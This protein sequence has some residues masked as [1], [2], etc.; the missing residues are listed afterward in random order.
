V[1]LIIRDNDSVGHERSVS[2][3]SYFHV[4]ICNILIIYVLSLVTPYL[5]HYFLWESNYGVQRGLF[6]ELTWQTVKVNVM[7]AAKFACYF[8]GMPEK[9]EVFTR[10]AVPILEIRDS[11]SQDIR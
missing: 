7:Y 5:F 10:G 8:K 1:D 11:D 6:Y 4:N 2:R 9:W 3:V